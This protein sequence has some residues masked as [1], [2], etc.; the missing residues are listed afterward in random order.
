[1]G[2]GRHSVAV[3]TA[4][5]STAGESPRRQPNAP[6]QR[7]RQHD[8]SRGRPDDARAAM[9]SRRSHAMGGATLSVIG[10]V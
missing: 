9:Q 5:K 3:E 8:A 2:T 1:M 6:A 7:G 4:P 10:Y